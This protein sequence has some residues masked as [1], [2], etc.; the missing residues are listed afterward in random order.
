[1]LLTTSTYHR[2]ATLQMSP[3]LQ[4]LMLHDTG[5]AG[6]TRAH[7]GSTLGH[8][9]GRGLGGSS[10]PN[11]GQPGQPVGSG[12]G[13]GTPVEFDPSQMEGKYSLD[14]E[15][16]WDAWVR[17]SMIYVEKMNIYIC[18]CACVRA[19]LHMHACTHTYAQTYAYA[20]IRWGEGWCRKAHSGGPA[21]R[22]MALRPPSTRSGASPST[23]QRSKSQLVSKVSSELASKW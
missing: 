7:S 18:V 8:S 6:L 12:E 5:G 22:W 1:M 20:Y 15:R 2:T 10:G 3:T 21:S 13:G 14:L 17:G 19:P 23:C 9:K 16:P 4:T 11:G